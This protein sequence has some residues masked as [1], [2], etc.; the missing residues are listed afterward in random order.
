MIAF[1]VILAVASNLHQRIPGQENNPA[2]AKASLCEVAKSVHTAFIDA[3][4]ETGLIRT[5]G[6]ESER[7][8]AMEVDA[9]QWNELPIESKELLAIAGWC[10]VAGED[11]RGVS[12]IIDAD[13]RN[14]LAAVAEG[15]FSERGSGP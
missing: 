14:E 8:F 15:E 4:Q 2:L 3:A 7:V 5:S 6:N 9:A 1:V 13:S 10:R 11:G 12:L